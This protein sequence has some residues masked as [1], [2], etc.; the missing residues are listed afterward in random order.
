MFLKK[1]GIFLNFF[2]SDQKLAISS[3][4]NS[5]LGAKSWPANLLAFS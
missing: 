5:G 3:K 2:I 1:V 4:K